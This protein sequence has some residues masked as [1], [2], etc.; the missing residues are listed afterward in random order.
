MITLMQIAIT[1]TQVLSYQQQPFWA[2]SSRSYPCLL[3]AAQLEVIQ[4]YCTWQKKHQ[5][6][7]FFEKNQIPIKNAHS[8]FHSFQYGGFLAVI[9]FL[10]LTSGISI[11][12]YRTTL[13]EGFDVGLNNSLNFYGDDSTK[14]QH[15]DVLQQTVQFQN[16]KLKAKK[17]RQKNGE[18]F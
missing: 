9:A 7:L 17:E 10:E 4:L 14:S 18:D 11:Y 2:L 3:V 5:T 12:T 8:A 15:V 6:F 13:I 1:A 16:Q